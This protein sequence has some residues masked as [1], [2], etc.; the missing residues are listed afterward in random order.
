MSPLRC[1]HLT[2]LHKLQLLDKTFMGLLQQENQAVAKAQ[3]TWFTSLKEFI[4][5]H[6]SSQYKIPNRSNPLNKKLFSD[7][8]CIEEVIKKRDSSFFKSVLKKITTRNRSLL[9]PREEFDMDEQQVTIEFDPNH[10]STSS[11]GQVI[12][13]SSLED[14]QGS[15]AFMTSSFP[16]QISNVVPRIGGERSKVIISTPH[17]SQLLETKAEQRSQRS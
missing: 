11:T 14:P 16:I 3:R 13:Q 10:P 2:P 1:C 15:T 12:P 6:A 8:E 9:K 5:T 4:P 17:K 7:A